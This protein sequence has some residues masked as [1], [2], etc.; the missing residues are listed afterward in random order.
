MYGEDEALTA[1]FS[2]RLTVCWLFALQEKTSKL[3]RLG[4]TVKLLT[5]WTFIP[6]WQ[7]TRL[8]E[9]P[10]SSWRTPTQFPPCP[11]APPAEFSIHHPLLIWD[12]SYTNH[13]LALIPFFFL[14]AHSRSRRVKIS[15]RILT[16]VGL[17]R[18]AEKILYQCTADRAF[19]H[20]HWPGLASFPLN[21]IRSSRERQK[22]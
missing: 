8:H 5:H 3:G 9:S 17:C 11:P 4:G 14:S 20:T 10:L 12:P 6:R 16:L 7:R 18:S 15:T 1:A 19:S 22:K 21:R 13:S 2:C